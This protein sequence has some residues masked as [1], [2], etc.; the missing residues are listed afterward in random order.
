MPLKDIWVDKVDGEDVV[1][2]EDINQIA[3]AVIKLENNAEINS[4]EAVQQIVRKGEAADRFNIGDQLVCNYT[5]PD[6]TKTPLVWDVIG[7]N[8]DVVAST[9]E[10]KSL[11]LQLHDCL[12]LELRSFNDGLYLPNVWDGSQLREWLNDTFYN[13]LDADFRAAIGCVDKMTCTDG[14]LYTFTEKVFLPSWAEVYGGTV[15]NYTIVEEGEPYEYY[16]PPYSELGS[17]SYYYDTNRIKYKNGSAQTWWLRTSAKDYDT[18]FTVVYSRG[19]LTGYNQ[20][21]EQG[22][23]PVVCIV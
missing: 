11:T 3:N 20:N 9:G 13:R 10:K 8:H 16:M 7:I 19:N 1:S 15:N 4:W 22:I 21:T 12:P 18:Q 5:N 17:P 2:A 14:I 23:A 6:G